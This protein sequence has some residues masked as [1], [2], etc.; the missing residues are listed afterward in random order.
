M[1]KEAGLIEKAV[2]AV[3]EDG[4]RTGDLSPAKDTPTQSTADMGDAIVAKIKSLST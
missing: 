4:L 1:E 3:L 2:E